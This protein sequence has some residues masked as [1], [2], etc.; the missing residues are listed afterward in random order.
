MLY[1]RCSGVVE[2]DMETTPSFGG[3]QGGGALKITDMKMTDVKL[4]DMNSKT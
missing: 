4:Q 3:I 2:L 1:M